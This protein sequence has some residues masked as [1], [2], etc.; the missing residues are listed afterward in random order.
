MGHGRSSGRETYASRPVHPV[1]SSVRVTTAPVLSRAM[2]LLFSEKMCSCTCGVATDYEE[3]YEQNRP[4]RPE[5]PRGSRLGSAADVPIPNRLTERPIHVIAFPTMC[6]AAALSHGLL[7]LV[8]AGDDATARRMGHNR[9]QRPILRAQSVNHLPS[10]RMKRQCLLLGIE[11]CDEASARRRAPGYPDCI[12]R[13]SMTTW[14]RAR[15]RAQGG[16][17]RVGRQAMTMTI[18]SLA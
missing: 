18:V 12:A 2:S 13:P 7:G 8:G 3:G 4:G 17:W 9:L 6:F 10:P 16:D 11:D 15:L 5:L 14:W 1:Y